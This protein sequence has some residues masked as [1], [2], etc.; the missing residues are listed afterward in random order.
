LAQRLGKGKNAKV[1]FQHFGKM[2][3]ASVSPV[4]CSASSSLGSLVTS[5]IKLNQDPRLLK[6]HVSNAN[7]KG[8][9]VLNQASQ[10][11]E[12]ILVDPAL[13]S[14]QLIDVHT[15]TSGEQLLVNE[16]GCCGHAENV[17]EQMQS[18]YFE[19]QTSEHEE[20]DP[21]GV[22]TPRAAATCS[23]FFS[24]AVVSQA[25]DVCK[26]STTQKDEHLANF[27][28]QRDQDPKLG[29]GE[30]TNGLSFDLTGSKISDEPYFEELK[31]Y[32]SELKEKLRKYSV[33]LV[34]PEKERIAKIESLE[35]LSRIDKKAFFYRLKK[36]DRHYEKYENQLSLNKC[37]NIVVSKLCTSISLYNSDMSAR[38]D[39]KPSS[40]PLTCTSSSLNSGDTVTCSF[41][42]FRET[43]EQQPKQRKP[44]LVLG[45]GVSDISESNSPTCTATVKS[46]LSEVFPTNGVRVPSEKETPLGGLS[47]VRR[48]DS[49]ETDKKEDKM[50]QVQSSWDNDGTNRADGASVIF[51]SHLQ[52]ASP[53]V[54]SSIH[55][56]KADEPVELY[57]PTVNDLFDGRV[58]NTDILHQGEM[59][60]M[61]GNP[62]GSNKN[63]VKSGEMQRNGNAPI[64]EDDVVCVCH[65]EEVETPTLSSK[66]TA[67]TYGESQSC[68]SL[69]HTLAARIEWQQFFEKSNVSELKTILEL[70]RATKPV[71]FDQQI[72]PPA[73]TAATDVKLLHGSDFLLSTDGEG[74]Y[75]PRSPRLTDEK[76][77]APDNRDA[78]PDLQITLNDLSSEYDRY[79]Q[80]PVPCVGT[81]RCWDQPCVDVRAFIETK[82]DKCLEISSKEYEVALDGGTSKATSKTE[83]PGLKDALLMN[84]QIL[85]KLV[86]KSK[87]HDVCGLKMSK[88]YL[89]HRLNNDLSYCSDP[90]LFKNCKQNSIYSSDLYVVGPQNKLSESC[91]DNNIPQSPNDHSCRMTIQDVEHLAAGNVKPNVKNIVPDSAGENFVKGN[92]S[93]KTLERVNKSHDTVTGDARIE[94]EGNDTV[95][96]DSNS[97][98]S[99]E[100]LC[101]TVQREE[102][103]DFS[104]TL[105][106]QVEDVKCPK[107]DSMNQLPKERNVLTGESNIT[108]DYDFSLTLERGDN[109]PH[110]NDVIATGKSGTVYR[111]IPFRSSIEQ[112]SEPKLNDTSSENLFSFKPI[113]QTDSV[114][115]KVGKVSVEPK[116]TLFP[117]LKFKAPDKY[118]HQNNKPLNLVHSRSPSLNLPHVEIHSTQDIK[119]KSLKSKQSTDDFISLYEGRSRAFNTSK[120]QITQ[121]TSVLSTEASLSKSRRLYKLLTKAVI[122][123]NKACKKVCESS[124]IVTK[125]GI[126]R[127]QISLPKSYQSNCNSFWETCDMNS[128]QFLKRQRCVS[129]PKWY[130]NYSQSND[131]KQVKGLAVSTEKGKRL[132]KN[133]QS[134]CFKSKNDPCST[135][136]NDM[137]RKTVG[138][139]LTYVGNKP[140]MSTNSEKLRRTVKH[141]RNH[142]KFKMRENGRQIMPSNPGLVQEPKSCE[143]TFT[144]N[145]FNQS[146]LN[147]LK[148]LTKSTLLES[149]VE[150]HLTKPE[151][152]GP[153]VGST[154]LDFPSKSTFMESL[155]RMQIYSQEDKLC[156]EK[157]TNAKAILDLKKMQF[158][159][160]TCMLK[161]QCEVK[162]AKV[163]V[164]FKIVQCNSDHTDLKSVDFQHADLSVK[165]RTTEPLADSLIKSNSV[166]DAVGSCSVKSQTAECKLSPVENLCIEINTKVKKPSLCHKLESS[167]IESVAVG[168][169]DLCQKVKTHIG[170]QSVKS[171][172][173][174]QVLQSHLH[175]KAADLQA[176]S[177]NFQSQCELNTTELPVVKSQIEFQRTNC[178]SN[179]KDNTG[180][181]MPSQ[182][183]EVLI[184]SQKMQMKISNFH[185]KETYTEPRS[186]LF[187]EKPFQRKPQDPKLRSESMTQEYDKMQ[188]EE[189][190]IIS[191]NQTESEYLRARNT[192]VERKAG[193]N[194]LKQGDTKTTSGNKFPSKP[195]KERQLHVSLVVQASEI[196]R[197]ADTSPLLDKLEELKLTCEKMLPVFISAFERSQGESFTEVFISRDLLLQNNL[198]NPTHIVHLKSNALDSFVELQIMMET[199]QFLENKISFL[200]GLPTFRSLLWYDEILYSELLVGKRGSQQQSSFYPSFQERVQSKCLD[201]VHD[202]RAQ[203]L[204]SFQMEMKGQN[205]YYVY[206]KHRRELEE[207]SAVMQHIADC[208]NF[209]LSIPLTTGIHFGGNVEALETLRKDVWTLVNKY[210]SLPEEQRD[211][212]KLV[213]LWIIIDIVNAKIRTIH[214]CLLTNNKLLWFGMEHI[215]FNAAKMLVWQKKRKMFDTSN[216]GVSELRSIDQ[217]SKL[218]ELIVEL[219]RDAMCMLYT[220]TAA[221][222]GNALQ[223]GPSHGNKFLDA[224]TS[225][226]LP[227]GDLTEQQIPKSL[228]G[229]LDQTSKPFTSVGIILERSRAARQEELEQLLQICERQSESLKRC[230]QVLQ[231]VDV[232]KVLVTE[233]IILDL[234]ASHNTSPVL[235][236]LEAVEI[237][238]ELI[239]MYETIHYLRNLIAQQLNHPTYRGMLWFDSTLFPELLQSQQDISI[240]SLFRKKCLN[241]SC[242][243]LEHAI[244]TLQQKLDLILEYRQSA[245]YTYAVQLLLRECSELI[246]IRTYM[247]RHKLCVKMYV[248]APPYAASINYGCTESE[249]THNYRQFGMVLEKLVKAPEKDLGKMAHVIEVMKSI[250]NMKQVAAEDSAS[251]I[252]LLTYQLQQNSK[253]RQL[254][255]NAENLQGC[256]LKVENDIDCGRKEHLSLPSDMTHVSRTSKGPDLQFTM[257]KLLCYPVVRYAQVIFSF[258][259]RFLELSLPSLPSKRIY[260][261]LFNCTF[262]HLP[263]LPPSSVSVKRFGTSSDVKGTI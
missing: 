76:L 17:E 181:F 61:I 48:A 67:H 237:Y 123:L 92:L 34:L 154:I 239:M 261:P 243:M 189:G 194:N 71:A 8:C 223:K 43:T 224:N 176:E 74:K 145:G 245:N 22:S 40:S 109:E 117:A 23:E 214:G 30:Q 88:N 107:C 193:Q 38:Q 119:K 94:D 262:T 236:N 46:R 26:R 242:A 24:S 200:K 156:A 180:A 146:E 13:K 80:H 14:C 161:S 86:R 184:D 2:E 255:A 250:M 158:P 21:F 100:S 248:N 204:K 110:I 64:T 56:E 50:N 157:G 69:L 97:S 148:F 221:S 129:N 57:F 63:E 115:K 65:S 175:F 103:K 90:E 95:L 113:E 222:I 177:Q 134:A 179:P 28:S 210:T 53:S 209:W 91:E 140:A 51:E 111:D 52:L 125:T 130:P 35:N 1:V 47:E 258:Y 244:S 196:L 211:V 121:L 153:K 106:L 10:P 33:F 99:N 126:T 246:A 137:S 16:S 55:T 252:H 131:P 203:V 83:T 114:P 58:D 254:L 39:V 41:S 79:L 136:N 159:I 164:E 7:G 195:M 127:N 27:I 116:E 199:V 143:A 170:S 101:Y 3:I 18:Q 240:F 11:S 19:N 15:L 70:S 251:V 150:C 190:K 72:S 238:I 205:A 173:E 217:R 227:N 81:E 49:P 141:Q 118:R 120:K 206:L 259:I 149:Q 85:P 233:A 166:K 147:L 229:D 207:S 20:F 185:E 44:S 9:S 241:N 260:K 151:I 135:K 45:K 215:Q 182:T 162:A 230:F 59:I 186:V 220:L 37:H 139:E 93:E 256:L 235:L 124:E 12:S 198:Q 42:G 191:D 165:S 188:R 172:L 197:E 208:C 104:T 174:Y 169:V 31:L 6:R 247:K 183:E 225:V 87:E 5:N 218:K 102:R 89:D 232:E 216:S 82:A 263:F 160:E 98:A 122:H 144:I 253:K 142:P 152:M 228:E 178:K 155:I 249:L 212:G 167:S 77:S 54:T 168:F 32:E 231:H 96:L 73:E 62:G 234:C 201:T 84:N 60:P 105:R 36:Y 4:Q 128:H 25:S 138:V 75:D 171:Q 108:S 187:N 257:V 132:L 68:D 112:N 202:Y 219:N 213:H 226:K 29:S 133:A 192:F 78:I 66:H 163:P